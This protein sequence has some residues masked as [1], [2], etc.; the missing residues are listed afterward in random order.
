MHTFPLAD[1]RIDLWW[2][3]PEVIADARLL[4]R[5]RELLAPDEAARERRYKFPIDRQRFLVRRALVRTVLS[6]YT[7]DDPRRWTFVN[8]AYGKP[9]IVKPA[10]VP[11]RFNLSHTRG[12]AVCAVAR[13]HDV[14]VDVEDLEQEDVDLGIAKQYFAAAEVDTLRGLPHRQQRT[15]FFELWTLKEAYIKAR[16]M[17]LSIPLGD[18]AF[19]I[20]PGRPP[21][22]SFAAGCDDD[23][24]DW[25]FAQIRLHDR[26]QIALA[27]C[28]PEPKELQIR[29]RETTPLIGQGEEVVLPPSGSNRW[30][31]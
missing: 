6:H 10:G 5:Y 20:L 14:G 11:L 18:F 22:I 4:D 8:N 28:L 13:Q 7:E 30:F 9:A 19:S 21:T 2:V 17:G 16:G 26:H 12:L 31:L 27:V 3:A 15:A 23:P 24:K 1:G 29:V 25:R